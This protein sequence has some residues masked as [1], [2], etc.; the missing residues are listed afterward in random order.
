MMSSYCYCHNI[1]LHNIIVILPC[2]TDKDHRWLEWFEQK[3]S[4]LPDEIDFNQ[5]KKILHIK[6]VGIPHGL[7]SCCYATIVSFLHSHSLLNVS[8]IFLIRTRLNISAV[9]SLKMDYCC[10]PVAQRWTSYA[11]SFRSMT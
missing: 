4:S 3:L 11:F 1:F 6:E 7:V 9:E 8:S 2:S 5:F 10:L